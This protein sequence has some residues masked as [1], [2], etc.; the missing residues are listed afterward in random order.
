MS[1]F[2]AL[3]AFEHLKTSSSIPNTPLP[4]SETE[5]GAEFQESLFQL[6]EQHCFASCAII[7]EFAARAGLVN[8]RRLLC[9]HATDSIRWR[10]RL[11]ATLKCAASPEFAISEYAKTVVETTALLR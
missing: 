8:T 6:L 7:L 1:N 5:S 4:T 3:A 10:C 2:H 9:K 11:R